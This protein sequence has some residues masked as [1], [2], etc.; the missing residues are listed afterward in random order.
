MSKQLT[1]VTKRLLLVLKIRRPASWSSGL[2]FWLL[3]TRSR[4]RF[5]ALPWGFSL[6]GRIPVVTM[7]WVVSRSRLKVETSSTRSKT[8]INS[9]WTHKRSP[10][11]RGPHHERQPAHQL[12]EHRSTLIADYGRERER[13]RKKIRHPNLSPH[14]SYCKSAPGFAHILLIPHT[15]YW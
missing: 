2:S 12:I 5:P 9:D 10:R 15:S 6:W 8:S 7:V 4:V 13:E 1:S 3:I 14:T 11:W